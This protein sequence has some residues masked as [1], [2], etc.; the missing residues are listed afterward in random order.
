MSYSE[1]LSK[2]FAK[3]LSLPLGPSSFA[4]MTSFNSFQQR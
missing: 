3:L 4:P 1:K 2:G